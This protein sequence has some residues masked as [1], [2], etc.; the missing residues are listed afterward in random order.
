[1]KTL[2]LI[3]AVTTTAVASPVKIGD[4]YF[5]KTDSINMAYS[6]AKNNPT[7]EFAFGCD[8]KGSNCQIL[9]T[10]NKNCNE[11]DTQ[12]IYLEGQNY[13][14]ETVCK[15]NAWYG[16]KQTDQI[17]KIFDTD[18]SDT[19]IIGTLT[20]PDAFSTNGA[21]PSVNAVI[22]PESNYNQK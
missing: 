2:L 6:F 7:H 11:S 22:T 20:N 8:L 18:T 10:D 9:Y 21:K 13:P 4:W 5:A 3:T 12:L 14:F 19:I 17:V 15:S 16:D 1:M